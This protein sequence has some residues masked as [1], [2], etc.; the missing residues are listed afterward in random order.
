MNNRSTK[1]SHLYK[2]KEDIFS[3]LQGRISYDYP[4]ASKV[5]FRVGGNA[6]VFFKPSSEDDL[7]NFLLHKP[8]SLPLHPLGVGSNLLIRDE[9][10][11]GCVLRLVSPPF[12]TISLE[13]N[14][15]VV[16]GA[17]CLDRNVSI[18]ARNNSLGGMEFLVGIPGT[19]GG[20]VAMN[21]GAYGKEIKD[22]LLWVDL[23][24]LKGKKT[25]LTAR[26]LSMTYRNGNLPKGSVVIQAAFKGYKED[27]AL[28]FETMETLLKAR[29]DSQPVR[30]R[31]GGSTFKNPEGKKAW[32]LIDAA[33]CRG[34][35]LGGAQVSEKH[36]NFL[37]NLGNA[38]AKDIETLGET[39]RK[40]VYDQ[41]HV[42]LEWEIIRLGT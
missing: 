11:K 21:A 7:I 3:K 26:E 8:E 33:G 23:I 1:R 13:E 39:V 20:A 32:Q 27:P 19:I 38:K 10:I 16:A 6:E 12:T 2:M 4:L 41:F 22:I 17:G 35:I 25:R 14:D 31:T 15:I 29:E 37:L 30:G 42:N 40:R 34:L 24:D 28:I 36:C 9:G 18:F 5:W